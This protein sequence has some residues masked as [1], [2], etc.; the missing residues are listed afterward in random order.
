MQYVSSGAYCDCNCAQ[1][2]VGEDIEEEF[3]EEDEGVD[4]GISDSDE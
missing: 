2:H 4:M 3:E 1:A